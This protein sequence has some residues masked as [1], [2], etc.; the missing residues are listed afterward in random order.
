MEEL[1]QHVLGKLREEEWPLASLRTGMN[2]IE[3]D[4]GRHEGL[5][6]MAVQIASTIEGKLDSFLTEPLSNFIS[7][8][9]TLGDG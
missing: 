3:E 2:R 6:A 7:A 5:G 9:P 4:L 8:P 1:K